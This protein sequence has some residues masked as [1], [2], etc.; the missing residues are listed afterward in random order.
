II[1]REQDETDFS[2]LKY[3]RLKIK[4][5]RLV[6][7]DDDVGMF[8]D[9]V[10]KYGH[11]LIPWLRITDPDGGLEL[12]YALRDPSIQVVGITVMMG[13][14]PTVTCFH[15][16]K[17]ILKLLE[18]QDIPILMGAKT[19]KDLGVETEAARFIIDTIMENPG[20]VEIL[21]TGPLTNIATALMMEPKLPEY[22]HTLHFATGEFRGALGLVSDLYMPSLI[23]IPDLNTNVDVKATQYVLEHGGS[24]PIYPNE[25]MDDLILTRS[26]YNNLKNAGTKISNFITYELRIND[27]LFNNFNSFGTG[28]IPHGVVPAALMCDPTYQSVTTES[29]VILKNFG[30]QGY[31]FEISKDPNLPKHKIHIKVKSH[32]RKRMHR[33]LMSR[34]I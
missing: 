32:D 12:I 27:F 25:V 13:V 31:A 1:H 11:Y 19:P 9:A 15:S 16:A 24:F 23:G 33:T 20:K 8:R 26:D 14:A 34:L 22:W 2:I 17:N 7:I 30:H 4:S 28:I 29:A 21:A 5:D 6:I 3:R 18:I 10:W